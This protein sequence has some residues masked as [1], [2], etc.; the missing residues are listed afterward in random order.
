MDTPIDIPAES[1]PTMESPTDASTS[2]VQPTAK[3]P[4]MDTGSWYQSLPDGF[5][6]NILN[7]KDKQYKSFE[8]Y[9]KST[10]E[11]RGKLSEKGIIPPD[12]NATEEER[13]AFLEQIKDYIPSNVPESY[14]LEALKEIELPE[15]QQKEITSTFKELGLSNEQANGILEFYGKELAKDIQSVETQ[16]EEARM[17]AE[18]ALKSEWGAEYDARIERAS[19]T[20]DRLGNEFGEFASEHGL[21]TR[22]E[23]IALLDKIGSAES[24]IPKGEPSN[25]MNIDNRIKEIKSNPKFMRGTY[26]E[27]RQLSEELKN[28]IEQ[29]HRI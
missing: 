29:K 18:K 27:R 5:D 16:R 8:D 13:N 26:E 20:L 12:E 1:T 2:V 4:E 17:E 25:G 7:D 28:L 21:F 15:E 23:F 6:H 22:K 24:T 11:L 9:V 14:E 19:K 10:H 3:V